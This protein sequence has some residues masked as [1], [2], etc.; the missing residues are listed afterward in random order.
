MNFKLSAFLALVICTLL[1][2]ATPPPNQGDPKPVDKKLEQG[3]AICAMGCGSG[4]VNERK[5]CTEKCQNDVRAK[6]A[7]K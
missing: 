2:L 1:V 6:Y 7:P 5:S 3:L 4:P